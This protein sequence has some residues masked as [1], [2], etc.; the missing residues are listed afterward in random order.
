VGGDAAAPPQAY[1]E[2]APVPVHDDGGRGYRAAD[3][4]A[5]VAAPRGHGTDVASVAS[6][7]TA[8][9][10]LVVPLLSVLAIVLG[11]VGIDRTRRRGTKGRGMAVT[12][13]AL[14][15]VELLLT[16]A[17]VAGAW[18]LWNTYGDDLQHGLEQAQELSGRT[19]DLGD[20]GDLVRDQLTDGLSPER[21]GDLAGT[22][23]DA[24]ELRDLAEQCQGGEPAA[25]DELLQH[26][27]EG[28][29]PEEAAPSGAEG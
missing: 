11:G 20:I 1:R 22:L 14:G 17:L 26:V 19:G 5:P 6:L 9:L 23:G 18:A 3:R 29:V 15:V 8:L 7:V 4:P 16:A 28:L 10:G 25:C 13:T 2:P 27:P 12:G 24:G 21:I